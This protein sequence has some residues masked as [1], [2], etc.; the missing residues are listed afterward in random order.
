MGDFNY[1]PHLYLLQPFERYTIDADMVPGRIGIFKRKV[2]TKVGNM[3]EF[4]YAERTKRSFQLHPNRTFLLN[5]IM[6]ERIISFYPE[7]AEMKELIRYIL[8]REEYIREWVASIS[9]TPNTIRE[10]LENLENLDKE[11]NTLFPDISLPSI[12]IPPLSNLLRQRERYGSILTMP[13]LSDEDK[14]STRKYLKELDRIIHKFYPTEHLDNIGE[15]KKV[16]E[17]SSGDKRKGGGKTKK[18]KNKRTKEQKNKRTKNK[19]RSSRRR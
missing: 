11:I 1:K 6:I 12:P 2:V 18:Q 14:Y 9:N 3:Y 13:D 5:P 15:E 17:E 16:G 8:Q 19:R 10:K 4:Q 7:T